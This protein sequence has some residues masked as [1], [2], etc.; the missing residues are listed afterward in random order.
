M[1]PAT[2]DLVASMFGAFLGLHF[3]SWKVY[4]VGLENPVQSASERTR[5]ENMVPS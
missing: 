1:A 2:P 4:I 5:G 3:L